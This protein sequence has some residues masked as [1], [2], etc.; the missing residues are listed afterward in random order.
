MCNSSVTFTDL[1]KTSQNWQKD[2][3]RHKLYE[4]QARSLLLWRMFAWNRI[5][6][7]EKIVFCIRMEFE[8]DCV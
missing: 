3:A 5:F 1:H 4:L 8:V 6:N 7:E 2:H